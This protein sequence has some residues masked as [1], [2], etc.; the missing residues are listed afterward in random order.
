MAA[1]CALLLAVD[2]NVRALALETTSRRAQV[3]LVVNG[4]ILASDAF[5]PGLK[6]AAD[7]LPM[8]D[9]LCRSQRWSP[10]DIQHVY[11]STG[12][13]GFTG[14]R[15]GITFAKTIAFTFGSRVVAVPTPRVIVENTPVE[16]Q[17]ALVVIDA[18]RGHTW[19]A[20]FTRDNGVWM[21]AGAPRLD[22]LATILGS[23][24]RP[25]WIVGEGIAYH[26]AAIESADPQVQ[27][28]ADSQPHV[29]HV[30]Q[31]GWTQALERRFVDPFDLA[32]LYVR[33]PEA[34]EKRLRFI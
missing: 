18:R 10:R 15:L 24:P 11:V 12:P 17:D 1:P 3:A 23:A 6:H 5:S 30:A 29:V 19:T 8:I 32:P 25:L 7:L 26:R 22:L 31:L 21:S 4:S 16:A 27:V 9:R 2:Q 20:H 34:E 33:R 14:S 28:V 13:G